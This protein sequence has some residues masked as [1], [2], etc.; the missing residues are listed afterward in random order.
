MTPNAFIAAQ[1]VIA[2]STMLAGMVMSAA[3]LLVF[4]R[5]RR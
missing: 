5:R 4:P 1:D 3:M 2:A